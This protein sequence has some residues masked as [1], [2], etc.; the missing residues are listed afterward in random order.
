MDIRHAVSSPLGGAL[1][2]SAAVVCFSLNDV[3]IKFISGDYALHQIVLFR[4]VIGLGLLI[5]LL[6]PFSGGL[7]SLRTNRLG[8]HLLRGLCVV[9][10]NLCFFL[11]LASLQL[12]EGTAIFFISPLLITVFSVVFLKEKV[13][14][15]RWAAIFVGLI[16]VVI[17]LRPGTSA[18]QIASLLP[19]AAAFGYA[20][21][22]MLTRYIGKTESAL[23]MS[24]YIQ[25][26]FLLV[27]CL[28]GLVTG[29]GEFAGHENASVDFLL[30]AWASPQTDDLMFFLLIGFASAFGG[31]F[32]SQAYRHNEAGY[33]APFEYIAM[34]LAII[35]GYL[36]FQDWPDQ[37]SFLGMGLIIASGLYVIWRELRAKAASVPD[38]PRYRR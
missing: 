32:I 3:S 33:I 31:F 26:T 17:I 1:C 37:L 34:P 28:F 2:A 38:T 15:H 24:F 13:G 25:V 8:L 4:S 20:F 19:V 29:S 18:F 30:R 21:L 27:C 5:G 7:P 10:A 22:H 6:V 35:W 12:A 9:F 11:G 14:Q 36:V 16:G 23:T